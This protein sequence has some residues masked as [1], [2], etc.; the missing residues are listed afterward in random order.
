MEKAVFWKFYCYTWKLEDQTSVKI[1][2]TCKESNKHLPK[3]IITKYFT[4]IRNQTAGK[5]LKF[6][7][8]KR[9]SICLLACLPACLMLT[10]T[11]SVWVYWKVFA[12][13]D[14]SSQTIYLTWYSL[15]L[16]FWE[17]TYHSFH[18]MISWF[19]SNQQEGAHFHA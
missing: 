7:E 6:S 5:Y 3:M 11:F 13:I 10:K 15:L 4:E 19:C 16:F 14:Q 8:R 9:A 18:G 2:C 12:V 1:K 17:F